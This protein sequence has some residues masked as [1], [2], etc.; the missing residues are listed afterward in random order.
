M[1]SWPG[2]LLDMYRHSPQT[3][4]SQPRIGLVTSRAIQST[5]V[6]YPH[7]G[8][9]KRT[10]PLS[11]YSNVVPLKED[12]C[13][14]SI[15]SGRSFKIPIRSFFCGD[16]VASSSP[17]RWRLKSGSAGTRVVSW[18]H[19]IQCPEAREPVPNFVPR[20][21]LSRYILVTDR[22]RHLRIH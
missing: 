14:Q 6:K 12:E 16:G 7:I 9:A 18:R 17:F 20:S 8:T 15:A 3:R 1:I 13:L 4:A 19:T 21:S 10:N 2:I 5:R 11:L 22:Y